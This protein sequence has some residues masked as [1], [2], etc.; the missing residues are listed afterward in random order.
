MRRRKDALKEIAFTDKR[1]HLEKSGRLGRQHGIT[2]NGKFGALFF[3]DFKSL[4][5]R[6]QPE[7]QMVQ[8]L[9]REGMA[10]GGRKE[11]T[12]L[13]ADPA[14]AVCC[15][16]SSGQSQVW[17]LKE[18]RLERNP[19]TIPKTINILHS[20][21]TNTQPTRYKTK[22]DQQCKHENK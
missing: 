8:G 3:R 15:P 6:V 1:L 16:L 2:G 17:I 10:L 7:S 19:Y 5:P 22:Q 20:R 9:N 11:V 13:R 4:Q 12:Q 14:N 18:I 21:Q